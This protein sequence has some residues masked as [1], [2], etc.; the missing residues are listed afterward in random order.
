M[1]SKKTQVTYEQNLYNWYSVNLL[2][3]AIWL[4]LPS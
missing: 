1:M 2:I 3:L 4:F